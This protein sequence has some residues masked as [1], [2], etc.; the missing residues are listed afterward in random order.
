MSG[1]TVNV[2][3]ESIELEVDLDKTIS[4]KTL[5]THRINH[6]LCSLCL[7]PKTKQIFLTNGLLIS[8]RARSTTFSPY[9][10][11]S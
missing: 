4:T 9:I 11:I 7:G 2:V 10:I 5:T 1:F 6:I 3:T 8:K